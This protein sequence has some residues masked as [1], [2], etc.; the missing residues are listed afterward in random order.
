M[1]SFLSFIV[2]ILFNLGRAKK[3]L[4]IKVT[5]LEKELETLGERM[6]KRG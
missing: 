3:G 4:L 2:K 5:L 1:L 6:V